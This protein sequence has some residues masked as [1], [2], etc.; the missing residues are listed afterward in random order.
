MCPF[1]RGV[2]AGTA[3][4]ACGLP[5]LRRHVRPVRIPVHRALQSITAVGGLRRGKVGPP[6]ADF[7]LPGRRSPS[8]R[9]SQ[10]PRVRSRLAITC[11]ARWPAD[12]QKRG[13][14]SLPERGP[15]FSYRGLLSLAVLVVLV[16]TLVGVVLLVTVVLTVM[17]VVTPVLPALTPVMSV[18]VVPVAAIENFGNPHRRRPLHLDLRLLSGPD[19]RGDRSLRVPERPTALLGTLAEKASQA[20]TVTCG[21]TCEFV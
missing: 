15:P 17:L 14:R 7:Q 20:L 1:L 11:G 8:G 5:R 9:A 21:L 19:S 3:Y 2:S 18:V 4:E 10:H 12:A 13:P 6:V 16:A